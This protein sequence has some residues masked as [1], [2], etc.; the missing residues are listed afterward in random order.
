MNSSNPSPHRICWTTIA[1]NFCLRIY[2][3]IKDIRISKQKDPSTLVQ[4]TLEDADTLYQFIINKLGE[5]PTKTRKW[6]SNFWYEEDKDIDPFEMPSDCT[7]SA[8][9]RVVDL[10][11][12]IQN[13][14]LDDG[15]VTEVASDDEVEE[16][17]D[18]DENEFEF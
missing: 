17:D 15:T 8:Y 14:W 10:Y 6:Q 3:S 9:S 12:R 5:N 18:E 4:G 2:K 11:L 13:M 7:E 16:E 1:L